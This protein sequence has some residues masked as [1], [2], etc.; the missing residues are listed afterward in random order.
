MI[1]SHTHTHKRTHTGAR[2]RA[3]QYLCVYACVCVRVCLHVQVN[4]ERVRARM[5]RCHAAE[6]G[7]SGEGLTRGMPKRPAWRGVVR[8][9]AELHALEEQAFDAW[10]QVCRGVFVYC[11]THLTR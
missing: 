4:G 2:A 10:Q 3:S 1:P 7:F 9:A 8:S 5:C 11:R 6:V